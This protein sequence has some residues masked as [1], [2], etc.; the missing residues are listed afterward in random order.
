MKDYLSIPG[1]K[2]APRGLP[3]VA[4]RK[5][6]GSNIR[7]EWNRKNGF[8]K[9]GSRNVLLGRDHPDL[10]E[11]IPL[12]E[13]TLAGPL[14]ETL[15]NNRNLQSFDS[16]V[17][18][19]EF[20]GPNSFAGIHVAGEPKNLVIIDVN[21]H[22]RGIVIPRDFVKVFGHLPI[23]EVVYEGNFNQ[24][25]IQAVK[26]GSVLTGE[27]VVAKGVKPGTKNPVHGLW[28]SKVKTSAWLQELKKRCDTNAALKRVLEENIKEQE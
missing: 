21:L 24:E 4:F 3:C 1:W 19:M 6:D 23:A 25:F 5:Y 18:F 28:M 11:A 9:Y 2:Q 15:Q 14:S 20:F 16:A 13:K 17:V 27:G 12:F 26:N 8:Y 22:K 10:G 7:T